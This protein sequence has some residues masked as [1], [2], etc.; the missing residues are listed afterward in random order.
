MKLKPFK[1]IPS[2]IAFGVVMLVCVVRLLR[3]DL[4]ERWERMTYDMR[5]RQAAKAEPLVATNL[6]FVFINEASITYVQTNKSFGYG[7]YWPRSVYGR[8]VQ[9][10]S[11]QGAKLV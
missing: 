2:L 1:R 5:V 10:L 11:D 4:I 9:E 8:L 7:L 3:L 6:G